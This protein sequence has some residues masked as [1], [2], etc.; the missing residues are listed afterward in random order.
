MGHLKRQGSDCIAVP[1]LFIFSLN[2]PTANFGVVEHLW[3]LK[4]PKPI[5]EN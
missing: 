5:G 4:L 2:L 3:P 1:T